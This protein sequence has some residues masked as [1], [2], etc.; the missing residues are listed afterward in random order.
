MPLQTTLGVL[1]SKNKNELQLF[2][3]DNKDSVL[4][5][6]EFNYTILTAGAQYR[7]LDDQL[8]LIGLISP[9]FGAISRVNVQVGADYV[10]KERHNFILQV[11][12]IKNSGFAD[13]M[14]ASL[15]Y[16]FSF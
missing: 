12:Y 2:R 15:I 5:S 7:M 9:A 3:T 8:R 10:Y 6:A 14:I 4:S 1:Y 13:D 16:R 11:D